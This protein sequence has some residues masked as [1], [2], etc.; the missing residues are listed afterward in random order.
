[1]IRI[2]LALLF[3]HSFSYVMGQQTSLSSTVGAIYNFS[4]GDTFEYSETYAESIQP[5]CDKDYTTQVVITK[6]N[7]IGDTIFYEYS[8]TRIGIESYCNQ[9]SP[10][11]PYSFIRDTFTG[12]GRL[13]Y[14]DSTIFKY[15]RYDL[16]FTGPKC[17][18]TSCDFDA[19]FM[20][21][22]STTRNEHTIRN[23]KMGMFYSFVEGLGNVYSHMYIESNH[24]LTNKELIFYHK[25]SGDIWGTY[26]PITN[27]YKGY[28]PNGIKEVTNES[29]IKI[30]PNPTKD[31]LKINIENFS[32]FLFS[33]TLKLTFTNTLGQTVFV[34]NI[35]EKEIE[36]NCSD[37]QKGVYFWHLTDDE[38]KVK[39]GKISLIH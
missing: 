12:T 7:K 36:I 25:V 14:L 11:Y 13:I 27:S 39:T 29:I 21:K 18:I 20:N 26:I 4:V 15:A 6:Y 2:L 24:S 32:S 31:I 16:P 38:M 22:Y 10:Y 17:Y 5:G 33:S 30:F 34:K 23:S 35:S 1:M 8:K 9:G 3:A 28:Y 37:W 19:E